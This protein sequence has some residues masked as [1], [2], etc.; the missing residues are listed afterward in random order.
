[1]LYI[2]LVPIGRHPPGSTLP[3][4]WLYNNVPL[5]LYIS[6]PPDPR[7]MV[8]VDERGE[9]TAGGFSPPGNVPPG[10]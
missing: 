6:P 3:R 7:L 10:G 1:M 8:G 9:C 5:R 4:K 2:S